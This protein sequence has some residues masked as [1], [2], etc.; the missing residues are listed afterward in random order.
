M[1]LLIFP[2]VRLLLMTYIK[3][4]LSSRCELYLTVKEVHTMLMQNPEIFKQ[5][6][7]RGKAFKRAKSTQERCEKKLSE[8]ESQ[9]LD[10]L[11]Q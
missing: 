9:I 6:V 5:S 8:H 10:D 2:K 11:I 4:K 3:I 7:S 1:P